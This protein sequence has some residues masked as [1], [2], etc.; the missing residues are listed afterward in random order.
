LS[1][2]NINLPIPAATDTTD[3]ASILESYISQVVADNDGKSKYQQ[4]YYPA[5]SRCYAYQPTV[6]E[7][8]VL[9]DKFKA[10]CWYAPSSGELARLYWHSYKG[11]SYDDDKIKNIFATA[12]NEG[13]FS[14]MPASGHWSSS[15]GSSSVAWVVN[16]SNGYF[17]NGS[18]Y[19]SVVVRAV[20]AF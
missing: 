15:E 3:E 18:K 9:A 4:F 8:E 12:I 19:G 6:K 2:S 1:D 16:F 10:H 20:A 14:K 5:I 17:S 11:D 7:G 13:V